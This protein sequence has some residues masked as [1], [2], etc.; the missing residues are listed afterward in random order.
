[1][2]NLFNAMLLKSS[3]ALPPGNYLVTDDGA[4]VTTDDGS[5]IILD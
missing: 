2:A 5:Y 1:M 3:D 4:Y